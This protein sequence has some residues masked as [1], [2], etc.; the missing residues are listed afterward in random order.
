MPAAALYLPFPS[1]GLGPIRSFARLT[2]T[3]RLFGILST[4][5]VCAFCCVFSSDLVAS[6]PMGKDRGVMGT[7]T[8][9][10]T[11]A[12]KGT[13]PFLQK[14]ALSSPGE[15][16]RSNPAK[17]TMTTVTLSSVS[18]S[19]ASRIT[20]SAHSPQIAW[21]LL[22]GTDAPCLAAFHT[23]ST[24]SRLD[25][26]SNIPSQPRSKKSVSSVTSNLFISG[27]ATTT[28]DRPPNLSTLASTSPKVLHTDRPP[29]S[30]L[31]RTSVLARPGLFPHNA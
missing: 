26:R 2:F 17:A 27:T 7:R 4:Y 12:I 13:E 25:S 15:I 31:N 22:P 19:I 21:M 1:S 14:T 24:A 18:L 6:D 9:A 10:G 20:A 8:G 5:F 16:A 23:A 3:C 29:G 11:V 30:T 28:P